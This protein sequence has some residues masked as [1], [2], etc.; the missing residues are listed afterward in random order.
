MSKVI[1]ILYS[2]S[3]RFKFWSVKHSLIYKHSDSIVF[4]NI[5]VFGEDVVIDQTIY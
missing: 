2:I 1:F 5:N 3:R 4:K